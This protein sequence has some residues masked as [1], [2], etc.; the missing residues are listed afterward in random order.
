MTKLQEEWNASLRKRH[1]RIIIPRIAL[2]TAKS[3]MYCDLSSHACRLSSGNLSSSTIWTARILKMWP[4]SLVLQLWLSSPD[5]I[6]GA[7]TFGIA[8]YG[9]AA[10]LALLPY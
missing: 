9:I 6:G 3:P 7:N 1:I 10:S 8:W 2:P 5:S 4:C